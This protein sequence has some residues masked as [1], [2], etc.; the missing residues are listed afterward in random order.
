M[1]ITVENICDLCEFEGCDEPCDAW[2]EC[3]QGKPLD[4]GII[5]K[6]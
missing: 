1:T 5:D 4:F 6:E 3:L 2:Y